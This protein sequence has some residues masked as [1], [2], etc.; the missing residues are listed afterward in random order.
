MKLRFSRLDG[1]GE[2]F[3]GLE[4]TVR[5]ME[6]KMGEGEGGEMSPR[7]RSGEL[8]WSGSNADSGISQCSQVFS[9]P[10][11]DR[12]SYMTNSGPIGRGSEKVI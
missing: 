4:G 12:F 10:C 1:A 8:V 2:R 3:R 5:D 11:G 9:L 7:L 6:R